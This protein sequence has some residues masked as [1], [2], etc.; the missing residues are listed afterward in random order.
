MKRKSSISTLLIFFSFSFSSVFLSSCG[1]KSLEG[2]MICT[3]VSGKIQQQNLWKS[4]TPSRIVAVDP[5]QPE[6]SIKALTEGYYSAHSPEISWDGKSLLFTA[7]QKQND[8]W[9]IYEMNLD[10]FKIKQ[11]T[12]SDVNCSNAVHLPNGRFVFG[13]LTSKDSVKTGHPLFTCNPDGSDPKQITYNRNAYSALT[14]LNDGRV[15]ALDK[16]SSSDKQKNI[17]MVMRPDGTKA[18]LFYEGPVGS[19]LI[20][21]VSETTN[22]NIFFVESGPGSQDGTDI[23]SISYNRPLHSR[24]N[25]TSEIKG[26]FQSVFPMPF[27]KLLVSYRSSETE[28][29]SVY[30]FDPENKVL[31]KPVYSSSDYDVCEIAVV[32]QNVRPKK[33]PS[34]VDFG[35]K[36]GLLL[37]QDI[38]FLDPNSITNSQVLQKAVAIEIM[39]TDS[40]MGVVPVEKDGSF[41]LKV[42]ADT[43]FHIRTL[44]EN[45]KILNHSCEWI[46]IRPNE[47]RGCVGCHEDHEQTPENRVPLAVKNLP[48]NVPVHIEKIKEKKI[49]LE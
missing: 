21:K 13:L 9:H 44:D 8:A 25:L 39:G 4:D 24:V 5:T 28:R 43:P 48:V 47:R 27:G 36:T 49:S 19:N 11:V 6:G 20:S 15:L 18:E 45:G 14:V 23:T 32:H 38:N 40:S 31:G 2:M 10:N 41:Y 30:E 34:E 33:L 22:G 17:L 26:D 12:S 29:Y 37:C 1:K 3:E 16:T 7:K 46:W 42:I 35:V